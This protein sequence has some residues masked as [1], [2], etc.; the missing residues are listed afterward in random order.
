MELLERNKSFQP[1]TSSADSAKLQ[2]VT[3]ELSR[4][5]SDY[6]RLK[7]EYDKSSGLS[8]SEAVG[9]KAEVKRLNDFINSNQDALNKLTNENQVLLLDNQAFFSDINTL[10]Q[11]EI[12]QARIIQDLELRIS[13]DGR[14][15]DNS[16]SLRSEFNTKETKYLEEIRLLK[17]D[18]SNL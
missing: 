10:K 2:S 3:S 16:T 8:S 18:N 5:Q 7:A 6:S 4:L 9:L 13:Q 15:I 12:E 14:T 1:Q 11:K 17:Q